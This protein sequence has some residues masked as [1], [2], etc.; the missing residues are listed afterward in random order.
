MKKNRVLIFFLVL[1]LF[2]KAQNFS[3]S[4]HLIAIDPNSSSFKPVTK[5]IGKINQLNDS[6]FQVIEF[7]NGLS[8]YDT[9]IKHSD[10]LFDC[11]RSFENRKLYFY[12]NNA[13]V[14]YFH[15]EDSEHS[16]SFDPQ[17]VAQSTKKEVAKSNV[18][19]NDWL[20]GNSVLLGFELLFA[21]LSNW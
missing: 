13:R 2:T 4:I 15:F 9:I 16:R 8:T 17:I 11:K 6:I 5:N 10:E 3:A 12:F 21:V 14:S 7:R 1:S 20:I 19:V 18:A